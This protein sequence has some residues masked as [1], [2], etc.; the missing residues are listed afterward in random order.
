M[1]EKIPEKTFSKDI[2]NNEIKNEPL[3]QTV[4][5]DFID[6]LPKLPTLEEILKGEAE[7]LPIIKRKKY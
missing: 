3:I 4:G 6:N 5:P 1:Q 2:E 7:L